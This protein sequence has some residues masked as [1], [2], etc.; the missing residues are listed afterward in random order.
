MVKLIRAQVMENVAV[1]TDDERIAEAVRAFGGVAVMTSA[2][3][4]SGTDRC[5]E[6]YAN[7]GSQA[8]VVINIQ[9]DEPFIDPSQIRT[10]PPPRRRSTSRRAAPRRSSILPASS[11]FSSFMW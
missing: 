3:H 6:A 8:G 5:R 10:S 7:L 11:S 1:A 2:S 9:G 4:R